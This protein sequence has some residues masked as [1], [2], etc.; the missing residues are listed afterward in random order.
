MPESPLYAALPHVARPLLR[1]QVGEYNEA[2]GTTGTT[3][4]DDDV[5]SVKIITGTEDPE[6]TITPA[7]A[8]VELR[9]ELPP[10]NGVGLYVFGP[11]NLETPN[12]PTPQWRFYG[13]ITTQT[14]RRRARG[15]TTTVLRA[16]SWSALATGSNV[17]MAVGTGWTIRD[18]L[19][20][21][22][23]ILQQI[24]NGEVQYYEPFIYD[25]NTL[26]E[27]DL[28]ETLSGALQKYVT[29]IGYYAFIVKTGTFKFRS[30]AKLADDARECAAGPGGPF[31]V[32]LLRSQVLAPM[33]LEQTTENAR[34]GVRLSRRSADGT[35]RDGIW[36]FG[37]GWQ[38]SGNTTVTEWA[39]VDWSHIHW[40]D[41]QYRW[42]VNA[43]AARLFRTAFTS[44]NVTLDL[45]HLLRDGSGPNWEAGKAALRVEPGDWVPFGRDWEPA[46]RGV[47]L[48]T[49]ITETITPNAWRLQFA[50]HPPQTTTGHWGG[51]GA[52]L[53]PTIGSY[54]GDRYDVGC[55]LYPADTCATLPGLCSD[56]RDMED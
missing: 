49:G 29:D 20:T 54:P 51:P 6:P 4:T 23:S 9:G 55:N 19:N 17:S 7:R 46:Y 48:V 13:K 26:H 25:E 43:V 37:E 42:A 50:V 39:D 28:D 15:A 8:E 24:S 52:Y 36:T 1:V 40:G 53:E 2:A 41:E 31:P 3:Y 56:Y 5:L 18:V 30:L 11:T 27:T 14:V 32:P 10:L 47:K 35:L 34:I 44:P 33:D 38:E 22:V 45:M 21:A 12:E 16:A